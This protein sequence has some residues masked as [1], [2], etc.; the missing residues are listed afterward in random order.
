MA[1]EAVAVF[2]GWAFDTFD[3]FLRLEAE[4]FEVNTANGR[5]LEKAGF[6]LEVRHRKAVEKLGVIMDTLMYCK[7]RQGH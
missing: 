3:F 7:F 2:S 1:T 6:E 5:V 4:V